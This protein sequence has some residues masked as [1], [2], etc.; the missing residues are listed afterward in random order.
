[1]AVLVLTL[2]LLMLW[3]HDWRRVPKRAT[4]P[5]ATASYVLL[6]GSTPGV[7]GNPL[8]NPW[9]GP[10]G[11]ALP[12]R[13]PVVV[14]TLPSPEYT[15]AR[16]MA[17]WVPAAVR[18]PSNA[19][20]NLALRPVAEVLT[21]VARVTNCL[22]VTLSPQLQRS[23]FQFE[24]PPGVATTLPAVVRFYL[25]LDDKGAVQH[26]LA[27]PS[28]NPA[29]SRLLETSLGRGHG[30]NAARGYLEVSWGR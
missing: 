20:P 4:L 30:T 10:R 21:G 27:E 28:D 23:A 19:M 6:D 26:L 15:G 3:P 5:E 9:P 8:G 18:M 25:E 13:D 24:L 1:M 7:S 22:A 2:L 16:A 14:R 29:S 11:T 12:E 17:P